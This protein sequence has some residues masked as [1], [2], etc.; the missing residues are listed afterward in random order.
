MVEKTKSEQSIRWVYHWLRWSVFLT[1]PWMIFGLIIV[2]ILFYAAT[3]WSYVLAV[4]LPALAHLVLL[5]GFNSPSLYARR[6]TQQAFIL[7]GMRVL[8]ALFFVGLSEGSA[9]CLWIIVSGFL[10]VWGTVWGLQ[11]IKR[12]DCWLMRWKGE[13]AKLPRSWALPA[14]VA[15]IPVTD[16]P[17]PVAPTRVEPTVTK[18]EVEVATL[19]ETVGAPAP[20]TPLPAAHLSPKASAD[21]NAAFK[22]GLSL[23]HTD[24]QTEAIDCF[25][26]AFRTGPPDLRR[27]ALVE[28][29][30]LEQVETF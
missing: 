11:Q 4:L 10:W 5:F 30:K 19:P 1:V 14:G 26:A 15:A 6:H 13:G 24:K 18:P 28:L 12:G 27:Q 21:P 20:A 9:T 23:L 25:L 22:K 2:D 29:E 16:A 7:A 8:S 17:T 3:D